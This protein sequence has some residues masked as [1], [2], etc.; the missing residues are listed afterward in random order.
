MA[1]LSV[2]DLDVK[3]KRVL[4]R[5]DFNVPIKDGKVADQTRI[6]AALPTLKDILD[7]GGRLVL[8][9]HLGR[10]DGKIDPK[11]SLAPVA[12]ALEKHLGRMVTFVPDGAES[13]SRE[14]KDGEVMM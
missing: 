14:L 1:K 10:P 11:Y 2:R 5:V 9:T 3:G 8:A 4:V 13:A 12:R 7:R 6:L